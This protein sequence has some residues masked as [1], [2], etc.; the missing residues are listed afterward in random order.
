MNLRQ[1]N[2][3]SITTY[4]HSITDH[5][6]Y[7]ETEKNGGVRKVVGLRICI[8]FTDWTLLNLEAYKQAEIDGYN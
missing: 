4:P 5:R 2:S 3:Q 8:E 6:W 7:F 1:Y